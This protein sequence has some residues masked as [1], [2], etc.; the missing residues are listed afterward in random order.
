MPEELE[1]LW[2]LANEHLAI[3]HH[4]DMKISDMAFTLL[5]RAQ[6]TFMGTGEIAT[7]FVDDMAIAGL[8]FIKDAMAYEAELCSS[9]VIKFAKGLKKI[10]LHIADLI[11]EVEN[12][13]VTYKAA[14]KEFSGI[15]EC[16]GKEVEYLDKQLTADCTVFMDE[17]FHSLQ[18]FSDA[19]NVS[20][21]LPVVVSMAITHHSLLTSL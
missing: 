20:P 9:D 8:N 4:F 11:H 3:A 12:L 13:E 16:V 6:Q 7:K 15:L 1:E 10:Q 21:F 18:D 17:S 2:Q 14:Q 5:Q 19:F